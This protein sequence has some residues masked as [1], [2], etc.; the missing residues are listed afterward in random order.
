MELRNNYRK[1]TTALS[2]FWHREAAP[3]DDALLAVYLGTIFEVGRAPA[4]AALAVAAVQPDPAGEATA[5][6]LAGYRRTA[7]HGRP[8]RRIPHHGATPGP[9][10]HRDRRLAVH[11]RAAAVG[12]ERT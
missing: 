3:V 5:R 10:R 8:G 6:V 7:P 2:R 9:T 1:L 11:G 4:T 12:S